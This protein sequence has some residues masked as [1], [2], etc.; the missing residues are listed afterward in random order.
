[1]AYTKIKCSGSTDGKGVK[2]TTTSTTSAATIHTNDGTGIDYMTLYGVNSSGTA[3]K[4]TIEWG[5]AT[6][7]DNLIEITIQPEDGPVQIT[8]QFPIGNS[9]AIKGWAGTA[10]VIMI[11][12]G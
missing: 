8:D 4:V 2:L 11:Y 5:G 6:V 7:P 9:L 3:V 12:G 1:M 10:D